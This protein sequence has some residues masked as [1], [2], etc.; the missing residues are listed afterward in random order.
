VKEIV[1]GDGVN[2]TLGYQQHIARVWFL[3][4]LMATAPH[5]HEELLNVANLRRAV[6]A[7]RA[8]AGSSGSGHPVVAEQLAAAVREWQSRHHLEDAWILDAAIS[9][10]HRAVHPIITRH[11]ESFT[12]EKIVPARVWLYPASPEDTGPWTDKLAQTGKA[13]SGPFDFE[14]IHVWTELPVFLDTL[15]LRS[16]HDAD[17]EGEDEG[18][19]GTFD[20]RTEQVDAATTKLLKALRPRV[21][22]V[23]EAMVAEDREKN[24]ALK[25][26]AFRSPTPFLWLVRH[27]VLGETFE[28]IAC[29]DDV[30]ESTVQKAVR[31]ARN[32]VGLSLRPPRAR[33]KRK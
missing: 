27:R 18:L 12:V 28:E 3:S 5:V 25:P 14:P 9:T 13:T 22:R 24:R 8:P 29:K 4:A 7:C 33:K 2:V 11:D 31:R 20:P 26:E 32:Q 17:A 19:L 30:D 15:Y 1:L 10:L 23:L 21:R 6:D 16:Q